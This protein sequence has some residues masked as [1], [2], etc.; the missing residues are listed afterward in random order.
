MKTIRD[1]NIDIL[2]ITMKIHRNYPELSKY[3]KEMHVD[4]ASKDTRNITPQNLTDYFNSL[5]TLLEKYASTHTSIGIE[6]LT[7]Q[8]YLQQTS[9]GTPPAKEVKHHQTDDQFIIHPP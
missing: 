9:F 6:T 7:Q 4:T 3:I 1:L 8:D 2:N 5:A